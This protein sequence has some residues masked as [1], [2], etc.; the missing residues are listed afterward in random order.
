MSLITGAAS[1]SFPCF[2]SHHLSLVVS[3][4]TRTDVDL[5]VSC[6]CD[7]HLRLGKLLR[8]IAPPCTCMKVIVSAKAGINMHCM[9]IERT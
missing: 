3:L 2:F 1:S 9:Q 7:H 8:T 5:S 6:V 4:I